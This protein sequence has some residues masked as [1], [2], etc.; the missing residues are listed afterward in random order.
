[1]KALPYSATIVLIT[2]AIPGCYSQN[3]DPRTSL[4]Q[5]LNSQYAL[6]K[7]SA[8]KNDIVTAGTVLV[9]QKD[10]LMMYSTASPMPPLSTWKNGKMSKS[11]TQDIAIGLASKN[12]A[13]LDSYPHRA[14]VT[15][16]KAWFAGFNF[17]K[18][19]VVL[20]PL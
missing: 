14:F 7:L 10:G 1:M 8:D 17:Q 16:E 5:A 9:L 13:T 15:G 11:F 2:A 12:G 4:Q 6:T 3:A 18:D 19:G 20:L